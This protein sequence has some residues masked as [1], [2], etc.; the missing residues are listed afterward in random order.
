MNAGRQSAAAPADLAAAGLSPAAHA[1]EVVRSSGTSFYW[2]MR[3][4]PAPKRQAMYAI[5]AFCRE[6]DDIADSPGRSGEKLR[7]LEG[8]REEIA[9]LYGGNPKHLISRALLA[10][11][12]QFNLPEEEFR[13][14]LDGMEIDAA[15]RV[16]MHDMDGLLGYCRK[17]A[18][19]VGMLSVPVFG[20]P[21]EPGPRIAVALG[22][23]LQLTNIL[24][25]IQADA[26][27]DRLYL[28][29]ETLKKHGVEEDSASR[30]ITHPAFAG[31]CRE[32][33]GIARRY[34]REA[35]WLLKGLERAVKR[36]P[37]IMM[38]TYR[39][40]LKLLDRQGW[41]RL[42][43]KVSLKGWRKIALALRYGLF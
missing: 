16:R 35:E 2:A 34:Y 32:L 25:D 17:V 5:Y 4:L 42:G 8:W 15:G 12:E 41:N 7:R 13:A 38:H 29:A 23:A 43:R 9:R 3:L 37:V 21:R 6:V 40:T 31:A 20:M 30:A 18:G 36:P 22:N 10:P 27:R 39:E 19:A 11:V 24:R 1:T 28:P 33:S 14:V 26:A